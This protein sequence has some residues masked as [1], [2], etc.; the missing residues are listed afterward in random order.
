MQNAGNLGQFATQGANQALMN[1]GQSGTG[2]ATGGGAGLSGTTQSGQSIGSGSNGVNTQQP[3]NINSMQPNST[4]FGTQTGAASS[5]GGNQQPTPSPAAP[6]ATPAATPGQQQSNVVQ[7]WQGSD[8]A[9]NP[10]TSQSQ[11]SNLFN[12]A[13]GGS[14]GQVI[15]PNASGNVSGIGLV[16]DQPVASGQPFNGGMS[17]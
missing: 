8:V 16:K 7:P 4:L 5:T 15:D 6:A 14:Q 2:S 3:T 12:S 1:S 10:N 9:T 17:A 13:F 11:A